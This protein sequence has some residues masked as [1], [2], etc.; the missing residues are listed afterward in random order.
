MV[1]ILKLMCA[2]VKKLIL[3]SPGGLKGFY[4]LGVLNY[5]R[6]HY[7]MSQYIYSG[8]SAGAWN[9]L[10]MST[11]RDTKYV[12]NFIESLFVPVSRTKSV[13]EIQYLLKHKLLE[14]FDSSDW[15]FSKLHIGVTRVADRKLQTE[16]HSN[17]T[18]L[19]D[20]IDCC[21]S[22]SHIPLVTGKLIHRYKNSLVLDGGLG[23]NPYAS[24]GQVVLHVKHNMWTKPV[25]PTAKSVIL[26][27][28]DAFNVKT[29]NMEQLYWAGFTDA[30]KN[31]HNFKHLNKK[32]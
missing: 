10:I 17:F 13:E 1:K 22:S 3:V 31:L 15:D 25:N 20:A 4:M 32:I 19:S 11:N 21:I 8:A 28:V 18:D 12:N 9:S 30:E 29:N 2:N 27:F 14:N 7:D 24:S 16:I 26:D 5:L 6:N 23:S